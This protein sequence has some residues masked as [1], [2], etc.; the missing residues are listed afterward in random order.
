MSGIGAALSTAPISNARA[1]ASRRNGAKSQGPKTPEGKARSSQNAL[2]HG[3]RAQKHVV[4]HD[5]DAAA[6][7]ALEAALVEELAPEGALQ[8]VL[9]R[10]GRRLAAV[11]GRPDR[12]RAAL[13]SGRAQRARLR[14]ARARR[15][16]RRQWAPGPCWG[17]GPQPLFRPWRRSLDTLLRYRGA[18]MAELMRALKALQAEARAAVDLRAARENPDEPESRANPGDMGQPSQASDRANRIAPCPS[19][20][21][22]GLSPPWPLP[23][24]DLSAPQALHARPIEPEV[25]QNCGLRPPAP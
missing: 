13:L 18:A 3:L 1:E 5:E 14:P 21:S 15:G 16:A 17:K 12:E 10:R 9:A 25:Q 20:P 2:K 23:A 22:L 24:P 7:Q 8:T 11:P 6:F 19:E 4:L